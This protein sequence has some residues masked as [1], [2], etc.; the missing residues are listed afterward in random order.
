M[1]GIMQKFADSVVTQ[2]VKDALKNLP[3]AN[4]PS[5]Q[6]TNVQQNVLNYIFLAVG[7]LAVVMMIVGGIQMTTSQGDS[8]KVARAKQTIVYSVIGLI[9]AVLANAI[10]NFVIGS[11]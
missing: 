3:G 2:D 10:V 5:Q 9:V 7:V 1:I 11:L 4:D 8:G 6:G